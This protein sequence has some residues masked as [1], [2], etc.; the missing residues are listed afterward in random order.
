MDGIVENSGWILLLSYP[1]P[2]L[3]LPYVSELDSD[4]CWESK[5]FPKSYPLQKPLVELAVGKYLLRFHLMGNVCVTD[6]FW[7]HF[8]E[9]SI[10]LCLSFAFCHSARIFV[11]FWILT[12]FALFVLQPVIHSC[13]NQL[14]SQIDSFQ[15][16]HLISY[17]IREDWM[18][19]WSQ[20]LAQ[21]WGWN[22]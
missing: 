21:N 4:T 11:G 7:W 8:S 15:L 3:T 17:L 13:G 6:C 5:H 12:P 22:I 14:T 20:R 1:I 10:A 19:L 18:L 16:R 2:Y 9:F